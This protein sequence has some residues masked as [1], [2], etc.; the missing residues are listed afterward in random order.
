MTREESV[1]KCMN[2]FA[3]ALGVLEGYPEE[4]FEKIYTMKHFEEYRLQA[5]GLLDKM[6]ENSLEDFVKDINGFV[7]N[8]KSI[9]NANKRFSFAFEICLWIDEHVSY[10]SED[11]I[12]DTMISLLPICNISG[13]EPIVISSL[14]SN[15]EESKIW[16][17]PKFPIRPSV[18]TDVDE[19]RNIANRNVFEKM[20]NVLK[21][22]SYYSY[23]DGTRRVKNI[24][25]SKDTISEYTDDDFLTVAFSPITSREHIID[26]KPVPLTSYGI[27]YDAMSCELKKSEEPGILMRTER[28]WIQAGKCK[29][30]ILFMPELLG[31]KESCGLGIEG[32]RIKWVRDLYKRVIK[33]GYSPMLTILPSHWE[34]RRNTATIVSHNGKVL[35]VQ[36]KYEPYVRMKS[37]DRSQAKE[38]LRYC[39]QK[40][41]IVIHVPYVHRIAVLICSEFLVDS[42]VHW[43]QFL[44]ACL[45]VSLL[46]VPSYSGGEKDFVNKL[47][48]YKEYG[49]TVVWG[50]CCGAGPMCTDENDVK[51][52]IKKKNRNIGGFGVAGEMSNKVF[53]PECSCNHNCDGNGIM[54]C[55]FVVSIPLRQRIGRDSK[56]DRSSIEQVL[57]RASDG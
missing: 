56:T 49:T 17:N 10:L 13:G 28:D 35:G 16:I 22:F 54:S 3:E 57:E 50:N 39:N 11:E 38:A 26:P 8:V 52:Q 46:I 34:N 43:S 18:D 42:E 53:G 21:N 24:I 27:D 30:D 37:H 15:V 5:K 12:D 44:C 31:T 51:V 23:G 4:R 19:E 36:E 55:S 48:A 47:A 40:E 7:Q 32:K 33:E 41:T 45:A 14:N 20:N 9:S 25:V 29:V 6:Q 2:A 1:I